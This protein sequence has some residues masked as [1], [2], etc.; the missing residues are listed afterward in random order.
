[1]KSSQTIKQAQLELQLAESERRFSTL[2]NNLPGMV[3]RC[4]NAQQRTLEFVSPGCLAITGYSVAD[5]GGDS[6]VNYGTDI[7]D[8]AYREST[9][10]AIQTALQNRKSFYLNYPILNKDGMQ[11]WVIE[12]GSGIFNDAGQVLAF[13]G[14]VMDITDRIHIEA[15]LH[16]AQQEASEASRVKH[17]FLAAMS[18]EIRTPMNAVLGMTELLLTTKLDIKQRQF[19]ETI[20]RSGDTLLSII[21]DILDFAKIEA[22]TFELEP[23][24]FNVR[25]TLGDVITNFLPLIREKGLAYSIEVEPDVPNVLKGD[26]VRFRQLFSNLFSN[27]VKFTHHGRIEILFAIKSQNDDSVYLHCSIADTGIGISQ[28]IKDMLFEPFTQLDR[29]TTREFGGTGIGLAICKRL[30]AFMHGSISVDSKQDEG[31]TFHFSVCLE[32]ALEDDYL[33]DNISKQHKRHSKRERVL[34]HFY[35]I[36]VVENDA[37]TQTV[38]SAMLEALCFKA[39]FVENGKQA[40][41]ATLTSEYHFVFMDI[42]MPEMDG[43]EATRLIRQREDANGNKRL[44]IIALTAQSAEGE[45][46]RCLAAGMDEYL[47]KPINFAR[48]E[49]VL[50]HWLSPLPMARIHLPLIDGGADNNDEV[51]IVASNESLLPTQSAKPFGGAEQE[52]EMRLFVGVFENTQEGIVITDEKINIITVNRGFTMLTGYSKEEVIGRKPSILASE[53]N[54]QEFYDNMWNEINANG[55]WKGEIWNRRKNGEIY[56]E[57]LSINAIYN[58][59]GDITHFVGIFSDITA[60]KADLDKFAHF[61]Q[62]DALTDIPNRLL[63]FERLHQA[64]L[65][66]RREDDGRLA[67]LFIDLDNFKPVN[68]TFGHDAGDVLLQSVTSRLQLC[69][70]ESDTVGRLGGDEFIILLPHVMNAQDSAHVAQKILTSLAE[71]FA[72]ADYEVLI[73]CSIGISR[74]PEDHTEPKALIKYADK[75]MYKAKAKGR[76]NFQFYGEAVL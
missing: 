50:E 69:I 61:A 48:L 66:A 65:Q 24:P 18:H 6:P 37:T 39:D 47:T 42:H 53:R 38:I 34:M 16:T 17:A 35:Q 30:V 63:I 36:L 10:N 76:N 22:G 20:F 45:R 60:I 13:E 51:Q 75:A 56:P 73:S 59:D 41:E 19:V 54:G 14:F 72:V 32:K 4:V 57:W 29:S 64:L 27:A 28:T 55:Q 46:E 8:P 1:M 26:P 11:K 15:E 21:N 3:Y 43:Y 67:V 52:N 31:S 7:I 23:V 12:R 44:P 70:R 58:N 2:L 40:V 33:S 74:Y 62:Y 68:D 71:P 25:R 9:W 5:F 49:A